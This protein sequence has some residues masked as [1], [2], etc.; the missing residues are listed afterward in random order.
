MYCH[1]LA[2][3]YISNLNRIISAKTRSKATKRDNS[4]IQY[5]S[6]EEYMYGIVQ[7]IFLCSCSDN[8]D[9]CFLL[10]QYLEKNN[11]SQLCHDEITNA[12][13]DSHIIRCNLRYV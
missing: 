4:C 2:I 7:K 3:V 12:N 6:G 9:S 5:L 8:E 13:L 1:I 11:Y 10:I